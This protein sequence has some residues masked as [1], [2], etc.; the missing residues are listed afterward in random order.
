MALIAVIYLR[1]ETEF[2]ECTDTAD[3]KEELLFE[4]VLPV[5]AIEVVG[6]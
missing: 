1:I 5:A 2:A 6:D 4:T 3:T